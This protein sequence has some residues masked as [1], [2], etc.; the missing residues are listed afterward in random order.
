MNDINVRVDRSAT[1]DTIGIESGKIRVV[2][3]P[4]KANYVAG[5]VAIQVDGI[6]PQ[7]FDFDLIHLGDLMIALTA[8][9]LKASEVLLE[10]KSS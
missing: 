6:E 9:R 1:K 8:G 2:I 7:V 5:R 4:E 10:R 3:E